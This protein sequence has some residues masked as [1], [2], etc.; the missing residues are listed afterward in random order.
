MLK[1][2]LQIYK[3]TIYLVIIYLGYIWRLFDSSNFIFFTQYANAVALFC[4]VIWGMQNWLTWVR[5]A[6]KL[7]GQ[8]KKVMRYLMLLFFKSRQEVFCGR[9]I[10]SDA[11]IVIWAQIQTFEKYSFKYVHIKKTFWLYDWHV[12]ENTKGV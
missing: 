12:T 4:F 10:I 8:N 3:N 1:I 2:T 5:R 7:K 9:E 6:H 11:Y